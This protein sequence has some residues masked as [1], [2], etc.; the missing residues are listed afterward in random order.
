M[1]TAWPYSINGRR[2]SN[3][4]SQGCLDCEIGMKQRVDPCYT[5][6]IAVD[7]LKSCQMLHRQFSQHAIAACQ[8]NVGP[9][10]TK[11]ARAHNLYET[12]RTLNAIAR[13]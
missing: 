3:N 8:R 6:P 1:Q 4:P 12:T 2:P 13:K 7:L 11:A 9:I 5:P 10:G